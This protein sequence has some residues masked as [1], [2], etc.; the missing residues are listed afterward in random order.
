M[1]KKRILTEDDV[2][3]LVERLNLSFLTK[4]E[5]EEFKENLD[6]QLTNQRSDL[7]DKLDS[8]LKEILASREE[9]TLLAGSSSDHEDRIKRVEKK[10][11]IQPTV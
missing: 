1:V 5:F 10:L 11:H 8:I 2:D 4:E 3:Y 6:S 9:Q 7:M